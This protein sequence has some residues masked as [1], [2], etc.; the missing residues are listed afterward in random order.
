MQINNYDMEVD[1]NSSYESVTVSPIHTI[2][3]FKPDSDKLNLTKNL[4]TWLRIFEPDSKVFKPECLSLSQ[5]VWARIRALK[6]DSEGFNLTQG[7]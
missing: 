1:M 2:L 4:E 3:S 5:R 7:N 6:P